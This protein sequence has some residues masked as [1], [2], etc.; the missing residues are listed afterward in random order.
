MNRLHS[1]FTY[2]FIVLAALFV[3]ATAQ[4][5]TP[6]PQTY[7]IPNFTTSNLEADLNAITTSETLTEEQKKQAKT[8]IETSITSLA[9]ATKNLENLTRFKVELENAPQTLQT[10]RADITAA[11]AEIA[12]SPEKDD[13][14]MREETLLKLEQDLIVKESELRTLRSEVEG[15]KNGQQNLATR[16]IAA[17]KELSEGR[18]RLVEISTA[19]SELGEDGLDAVSNA[20]RRALQSRRYFRRTQ[21]S[22]LEQE[23]AG[24]AKRQ[25]IVTARSTLAELKLR[26]LSEDVQYLSEVTGQKRLNEA[27]TVE[28]NASEAVDNYANAHPILSD[29]SRKNLTLAEEIVEF[30]TGAAE[31]SKKLAA[32]RS[33]LDILDSDLQVAEELIKSGSLDRR[34]GA[35]LRRLSNQFTPSQVLKTEIKETQKSRILVTQERLI[36]QETLRDIPFGPVDAPA[37]LAQARTNAPDLPDLTEDDVT[38]LQS[39]VSERRELLQRVMTAASSRRSEI[40]NLAEQQ[41]VLLANTEKLES[42]LDEKLLWVPSVPSINFGWPAKVGTGILTVFSPKNIR[43]TFDVFILQITRL[44]FLVFVFVAASITSLL[45]RKKLWQDILD[46]SKKVGRVQQDN[47]WHTPA[48][49]LSCIVIALPFPLIFILLWL[50]F[51]LSDSP[52]QLIGGLSDAFLYVSLFSLFMLTW[53]VWDKDKSLFAAHYRLPP[54]FRESVN[55]QLR[56][57]IPLAGASTAL[58][59]LTDSSPDAS[60][61]GGFSVFAFVVTAAALTWFGFKV[62]WEKRKIH[63]SNF[64]KESFFIKYKGPLTFVS[65]GLPIIAGGLALYGYYDTAR[66]LLSRLFLSAW[67]FL[68]TYVVHGLI[69]RTILVAQR[70]IA[71]RQALEKRDVALKAK[72]EKLKAEESGEE[73][74]APTPV[75]TS[76]IDVKAMSRQSAQL[77]STL[78]LLGFAAAMWLIWS[79]LLPALSIFNEVQIGS[80][81]GQLVDEAGVLKD[82]AIPITLWNLMQ[83]FVILILTFIAAKNLPGFLEIFVLNRAGVDAGTRYAIKTIL[84]YIIIAVGVV[85]SFDKLGLQWSQLKWIVT[86]LSVGIGLGLQKIIANFVSGLIILFERPVRIGDYVTIGEQ[87]GTVSRIQIRATTLA[88]LE[89]REIL[90]PNEALIS[91][92]V[93][94]WTLSNSV[95]RLTVPVGIAYGSDTDKARD[96]MLEALNANSKILEMPAPQVLFVGFGDSSLNF[97]LRVFLRNFEDRVNVRHMVHTDIN[98][99]LAKAGISIPFPQTDLNIVSQKMPLDIA[100]KAAARPSKPKTA[101]AKP[102]PQAPKKTS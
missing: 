34:A 6:E 13:E 57:F 70:Q 41:S 56:W 62:L 97:E 89:N 47:Y 52:D 4:A 63:T 77:L 93:T 25:E 28:F 94:N 20:N 32:T 54:G 78:I 12:K 76:E 43:L 86:G 95:T 31:V 33:R 8:Y 74:P 2:I 72:I 58:I 83:F 36:A 73:P 49:I 90:I 16:Q 65:V 11:Q 26:R 92:R 51:N 39:L 87:S 68:L 99:V 60:V 101:A 15:Y 40:A 1:Y 14:P 75:D 45:I 42:T 98:K 50:L 67:L 5:Q 27:A 64:D 61:Y 30:A 7:D 88:D 82:I 10:L 24:L 84:G 48:V 71:F 96:L 55:K 80:Y 66:E 100:S 38:A 35:T 19:L 37:M 102:K 44:W 9:N 79:D 53:R 18:T 17:P 3:L 46:R 22:S 23:I 59:A 69:K 21:I 91:E 85:I 29:L 81:T